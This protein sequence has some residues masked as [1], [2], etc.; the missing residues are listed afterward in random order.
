MA[1]KLLNGSVPKK[2]IDKIPVIALTAYAM[3]DNKKIIENNGFD[4]LVT[5]PINS[6]VL[7]CQD[8]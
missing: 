5:K 3:L 7:A 4:D 6:Q 2:R 8:E 1:S